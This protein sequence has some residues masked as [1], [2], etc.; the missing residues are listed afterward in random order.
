VNLE[1][2]DSRFYLVTGGSRGVSILATCSNMIEVF[3]FPFSKKMYN[4]T[5]ERRIQTGVVEVNTLLPVG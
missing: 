4:T 3:L 5:K 2:G 1:F